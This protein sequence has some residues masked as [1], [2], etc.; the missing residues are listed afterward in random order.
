MRSAPVVGVIGALAIAL[1]VVVPP[2]HAFP[3]PR[4]APAPVVEQPIDPEIQRLVKDLGANDYRTREKAGQ[5][6]SAK[7]EK[8]LHDMRRALAGVTDP[9]VSRRLS[10]LVRKMDHDRLV[11]PKRVSLPKK[12]RSVKETL[13]E[14]GNQTGYKIDERS[15]GTAGDNRHTFELDNLPFWEAIDRVA[16]A[17]GLNVVTDFDDDTVRVWNQNSVNPYVSYA[18]PFRFLATNIGSS[19][20]VS[21]SGVGRQTGI[22]RPPEYLSLQF[23]VQ[24]EP[25]NPLLGVTQAEVLVATDEN[26][27][28]LVPSKNDDQMR[29]HRVGYYNPGYRGHN[30]TAGLS[31]VRGDKNAT[32][33]KTL[34]GKIGIILLAA[35]VPDIV[36]SDPLKVKNQKFVGRT[37]E[38]DVDSVNEANGSYTVAF[39]A[40][41]AGVEG[42]QPDYNWMNNIWQKMELQ[43]AAGNKYHGNNWNWGQNNGMAVSMTVT[44]GPNDRRG[45]APKVKPGPAVKLVF[46]EWQSV[47]HEVTF[48]FKNVPLP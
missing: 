5:Q 4:A 16:N 24:S 47:T 13:A 32:T 27:A 26:G 22:T 1:A 11:A 6:L 35:V 8:A 46:N 42:N 7:G 3:V 14:I 29:Y 34:R 41:R 12:E 38:L 18:G 19:K 37:V 48:E 45:N 28:S 40:R 43:D 2:G 33:I 23:Q 15:L 20:N 36:V 21:L 31:L 9:E 44:F 17:A 10:V 25:K 39:T 30:A